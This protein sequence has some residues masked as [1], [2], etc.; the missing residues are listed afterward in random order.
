[1]GRAKTTLIIVGTCVAAV[2]AM[3]LPFPITNPKVFTQGLFARVASTG[4]FARPGLLL[5]L[6][7][8][9]C[10]AVARLLPSDRE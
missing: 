7:G 1:M 9:G 3:A 5:I 4:A 6:V 8:L 2:G 10:L